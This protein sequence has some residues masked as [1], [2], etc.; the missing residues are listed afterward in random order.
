MQP[1]SGQERAEAAGRGLIGTPAPALVVETIDG[2]SIDLGALYDT[3]AVYLKFWATWCVPCRE[4]MPHFARVYETAGPDLAVIA[5]NTGFNDSLPAVRAVIRDEGLEMP[6]VVDDGRLAA[7][8]NLRVTPQH[9]V[10]GRDGRIAYIGHLADESFDAAL[11]AAQTQSTA[12]GDAIPDD[13]A[14]RT[15]SVT[16]T[17]YRVGDALPD[18][19]AVT[20]DGRTFGARDAADRR[21]TVLVFLS[22]WCESYL[23]KSRPTL[24][25]SCRQVRKQV[26][27]LASRG[28]GVRWLG[29]AS[30]LWSTPGELR[31]YDQEYEPRIP[32]TMDESGEWFRGFDVARTPTIVI[33]D[34]G[35]KIVQR[36]EGFDAG[37]AGEI[38]RL[39][40]P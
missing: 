7:A 1:P 36:I 17:R 5:V 31:K 12:P 38:E 25:K 8:F 30:G 10:I 4:Q 34:A 29:V 13:A 3:K 2:E 20:I 21:P 40:E 22:P 15:A 11:R 32:L 19:S 6:M 26:A 27:A 28:D 18:L 23:A 16:I 9:V 39:L 37:L 33:A 14:A 24:A 35:G